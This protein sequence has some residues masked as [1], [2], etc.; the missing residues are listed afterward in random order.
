MQP[1]AIRS[2]LENVM[3]NPQTVGLVITERHSELWFAQ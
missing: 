3:T 1:G 2:Y